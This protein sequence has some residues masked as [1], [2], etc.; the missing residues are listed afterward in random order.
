[1]SALELGPYLLF[2]KLAEDALS[3]TYRAGLK[4]GDDVERVVLLCLFNAGPEDVEWIAETAVVGKRA[5][6]GLESHHLADIVD[7]GEVGGRAFLAY[8]YIPGIALSRLLQ[9][10]RREGIP[11][12]LELAI[13]IIDRAAKGLSE[14]WEH[15]S[16]M[17]HGFLVPALMMVSNEGDVR[18]LG[19]EVAS[20]LRRL[21]TQD[22]VRAQLGAYL[23]PE[24]VADGQP[25]TTD[26]V[27]SLGATLFDLVAGA[28]PPTGE[29]ELEAAVAEAT[30]VDGSPMPEEIRELLASSL[31]P[32]QRRSTLQVWSE[33]LAEI[34]L[35]G[36]YDA[37]SF[38]LALFLHRLFGDELEELGGEPA[39]QGKSIEP[40]PQPFV[41]EGL[42][43]PEELAEPN[44]GAELEALEVGI[45]ET[46]DDQSAA[47]PIDHAEE[48]KPQRRRYL[49]IAASIVGLA[50]VAA[51]ASFFAGKPKS[52]SPTFQPLAR[53][54]A[55]S[56]VGARPAT[57]QG[58]E[59][60]SVEPEAP[61][62]RQQQPAKPPT[63][64]ERRAQQIPEPARESEAP[65]P[66]GTE[67]RPSRTSPAATIRTAPPTAEPSLPKVTPAKEETA[68]VSSPP[69]IEEL[70][71]DSKSPNET[72]DEAESDSRPL[73]SKSSLGAD[74]PPP[75]T[76][77]LESTG[78][79]LVSQAERVPV[80]K[81]AAEPSQVEPQQASSP[82]LE[83]SVGYETTPAAPPLT[84][85]TTSEQAPDPAEQPAEPVSA[86]PGVVPPKLVGSVRPQFPM[87]ARRLK[88]QAVISVRVLVDETGD[89]L[90]V[91]QLG[92]QA[93]YGFDEAALEAVHKMTW[94]PGTKDGVP[95]K[96]W[97]KVRLAF[98]P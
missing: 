97:S 21:L 15:E 43:A 50:L 3:E 55:Q 62:P 25:A 78:D 86:G 54:Q 94:E 72:A 63:S 26:D 20:R 40:T 98:Q 46:E 96:M 18:L 90:E 70:T 30:L 24:I 61:E 38:N 52:K 82:Q 77:T 39:V 23:P 65:P 59:A 57:P 88:K 91:E 74:T 22:S 34:V 32:P 29:E 45:D 89:I 1:M 83:Q 66:T 4:S 41:A 36:R 9:A 35:S 28:A 42:E 60:L 48:R 12:P 69:E 58:A 75:S 16:R 93:G 44:A 87:M 68:V 95:V 7:S 17:L 47:L 73:G 79:A 85:T 27:F 11:V 13:L 84:E 92:G 33:Q 71:E 2:H 81:L 14:A 19:I 56:D 51:G 80:R 10:S 76:A 67:T 8:D 49:A 6:A 53:S 64:A 5:L 31:A 37:T